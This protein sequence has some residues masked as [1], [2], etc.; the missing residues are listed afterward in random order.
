MCD[1]STSPDFHNEDFAVLL[2]LNTG[3]KIGL[4]RALLNSRSTLNSLDFSR[5]V[6][7]PRISLLPWAAITLFVC[8]FRL[9]A[10]AEP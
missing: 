10:V 9:D 4:G 8:S 6:P 5:W 7:T 3:P 2:A 1:D